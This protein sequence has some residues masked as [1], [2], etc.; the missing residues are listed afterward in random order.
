MSHTRE[1]ATPN[2]RT[3]ISIGLVLIGLFAGILITL[4]VSPTGSTGFQRPRTVERVEL[5]STSASALIPVPQT[6]APP[7]LFDALSLNEAFKFVA[8]RVTPSV[9]FIQV[10][11]NRGGFFRNFGNQSEQFLVPRSV[12]SGVIISEQGYVVTN[13]HVIDG[14][15]RI[16]VT[17]QDK[18]EYT[19]LIVGTDT[20]TDLAVLKL[21]SSDSLPSIALG[22]SADLEVGEW[23]IAVG[24]PFRL[25]STVTAGII[26]ALDRRVE[27][28]DDQFGIENFIQ[29]DAAIN[30]GNSGGALVNLKGELIGIATAIATES[31]SYEG[32][33]FAVPVDLMERVVTDLIKFGRVNRGYLGVSILPL[34][35]TDAARLGMEE[36]S[37]VVL[38]DVFDGLAG[39]K[40]GLRDG[41]ILLSIDGEKVSEPNELQSVIALRRPGEEFPVAVWRNGREREFM[42]QLKGRD[43]PA[44]QSWIADL[45]AQRS[46]RTNPEEIPMPPA[47]DIRTLDKWGIG[48]A[49]LDARFQGR[50][51][52]PHGAY[53]AFVEKDGAFGKA[54]VPRNVLLT[55]VDETVI[56]SVEDVI[57]SLESAMET[58][59]AIVVKVMRADG[60]ALFFEI[61]VPQE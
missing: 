55:Q 26:S 13:N 6:D 25:T 24:N 43:D 54:G 47:V 14:A 1:S 9:V 16:V 61:D 22:N 32:Y 17:L 35:A 10:Q 45:E 42:V 49:G 33:G 60:I 48:I 44:Y 2:R 7:V 28:N 52:V 41:D 50:F 29:T 11:T 34:N 36:V 21:E 4:L 8:A 19:A 39:Y 15:D 40:A 31:G 57:S 27:V 12:G 3:I 53:L 59:E 58:V 51:S 20:D 18:R 46:A 30:P 56:F 23:V 5:G 37:G 38:D